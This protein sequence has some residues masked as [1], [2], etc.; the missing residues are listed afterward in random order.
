MNHECQS[1]VGGPHWAIALIGLPWSVHGSGPDM[2]NCWEFVR[3]VQAEHFGE[4][5]KAHYARA[6]AAL[7]VSHELA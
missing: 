2:F 7:E 3:V 4:D 5:R 6:C 1:P